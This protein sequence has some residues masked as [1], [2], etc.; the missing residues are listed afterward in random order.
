MRPISSTD[1]ISP[2]SFNKSINLF[3]VLSF[4]LAAMSAPISFQRW[5]F[6]KES[7][8]V[9]KQE[10]MLSTKKAIKKRRRKIRS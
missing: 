8:K 4:T 9:R 5:E 10:N 3:I 6:I 1:L 2:Q 7:K